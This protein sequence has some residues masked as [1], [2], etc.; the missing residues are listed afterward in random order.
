MHCSPITSPNKYL[1]LLPPLLYVLGCALRARRFSSLHLPP[2]T[3]VKLEAA[4]LARKKR[5]IIVGDVHGCFSELDQLVNGKLRYNKNDDLL[6][7]VGDICRKGPDSK[8]CVEFARINGALT[9]RGNHDHYACVDEKN[10]KK[11]G[12][13]EDDV[14]YLM[15]APLALEL[16]LYNIMVVHAGLDPRRLL[17]TDA[18]QMMTMR[19][20][21]DDGSVSDRGEAGVPWCQRYEGPWHVVFGHDAKRKLQRCAWA[22]GIDTGCV[23]GGKLTA[24]VLRPEE[25]SRR[26]L[27]DLQSNT[28]VLASASASESKESR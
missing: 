11:L 21:L 7:F 27:V 14:D 13:D 26:E 18:M 10:R 15:K 19:N 23:Y 25:P 20:I 1:L 17:N 28:N 3:H 6:V 12:L 4:A 16:S 22:T 8:K 9:V 2:S 5:T 24:M